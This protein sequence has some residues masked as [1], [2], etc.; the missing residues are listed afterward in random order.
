MKEAQY[1]SSDGIRT[2]CLLCPHHCTLEPDDAGRCRVRRNVGGKM[3]TDAYGRISAAHLDPIEKK[4]LYHFFPGREIYSVGSIGCNLRCKFCQNC[5][6]SQSSADDLPLLARRKPEEVVGEARNLPGNI[7]LAYTYNE[8]GVWLEFLLDMARGGRLAGMKNVVISNGFLSS[9]PLGDLMKL[10]DAFNIDL[11]AFSEDFYRRLTFSSLEP[12]KDSIRQI[13]QAGVHLEITHLLIPG[14]NDKEKEF[15]EMVSWLESTLGENCILHLSKYFPNYRLNHPPT[16]L[17]TLLKFYHI[18]KKAFPFVYLGN[19]GYQ[20]EGRD[21]HCSDCGQTVIRRSGYQTD[22]SGLN[23][24]GKCV[25]C[26][27]QIAVSA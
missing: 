25:H 18:A 14:L 23:S 4:P 21:T 10:T 26:N 13:H 15:E 5:Q 11:K 3:V 27:H 22:T 6:I 17:S 24:E 16:P 2:E 19:V 12:V 8:P 1:Y 20:Q 7:G 9:G